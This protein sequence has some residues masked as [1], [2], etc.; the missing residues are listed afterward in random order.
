M[1]G[2]TTFVIAHRPNTLDHCD[3]RFHQEAGRLG[4]VRSFS[5]RE[6]DAAF[7]E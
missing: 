3:V 5:G 6:A 1:E 4:D 7:K 2:R